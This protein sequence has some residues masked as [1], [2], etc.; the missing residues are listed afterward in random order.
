M[1]LRTPV[2][3][4][5]REDLARLQ[6]PHH[7]RPERSA[8]RCTGGLES[9][10][11]RQGHDNGELVSTDDTQVDVPAAKSSYR[12]ENTQKVPAMQLSTQLSNVWTFTSADTGQKTLPLPLWGTQF[13]PAV[14][15]NNSVKRTATTNL[16][17]VVK[18]QPKAPVGAL[19]SVQVWIS[20]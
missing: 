15:L 6:A 5:G 1:P 3:E 16:P 2:G 20:R 7:A 19:K 11:H 13:R 10:L 17:F 18:Y 14:D 9:R 12:L 4:S 8:D